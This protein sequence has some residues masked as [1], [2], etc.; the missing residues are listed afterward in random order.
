MTLFLDAVGTLFGL[1]ETPGHLYARIAKRHRIQVEPDVLDKHFGPT[2]KGSP[3]PDYA[4]ASDAAARERIDQAWWKSI[5]R[6]TFRLSG[7]S[8]QEAAFDACFDEIFQLYGTAAPWKVYP[9]TLAVLPRLRDEGHRLVVLSNFDQRL[10]SVMTALKLRQLVDEVLYSSNLGACKPS[11]EAF[12]RALA[13]SGSARETTL[14][15]GDDPETDGK[16][17][18]AA[19]LH[20]FHIQRPEIDLHD[21]ESHL[22][23]S[24]LN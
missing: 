13:Q 19:G 10:E 22:R 20:F 5:V 8:P 2:W 14:H 7:A 18:V 3:P 17:A 11:P 9:E 23:E 15:V 1:R 6:E 24:P 21:L 12:A 16:G 4:S